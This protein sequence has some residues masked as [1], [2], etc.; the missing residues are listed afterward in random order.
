MVEEWITYMAK[1]DILVRIHKDRATFAALWHNLTEAQMT[2]RPGP[3]SDWSVKDLIAHVSFWEGLMMD[4]IA[5]L[6]KGAAPQATSDEDV[7]TINARVFTENEHRP[8]SDVLAEFDSQLPLVEASIAPLSDD[9]INN[10]R[11]FADRE[12]SPLLYHIIGNT[13]GHYEEHQPDLVR[14]IESLKLT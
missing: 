8:L 1:P 13:F 9:D 4:T 14:Y 6:T 12:G 5:K 2:H 10:P 3:Q 7:D 11:R